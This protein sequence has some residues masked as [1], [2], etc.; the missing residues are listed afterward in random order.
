MKFKANGW[1][2]GEKYFKKSHKAFYCSIGHPDRRREERRLGTDASMADDLRTEI[3]SSIIRDGAPSLDMGV[4]ELCKLFLEHSKANQSTKTYLGYRG[5]L[6][7]FTNTLSPNL[8][9]RDLL[10]A[11]VE[12][13]L[14]RIYPAKTT[15][16]NTRRGAVVAVKRV[17][18]WAVKQMGWIDRSPL[19]GYPTP[20]AVP[21]K[22]LLT[23][24]QWAV[25][26][27]HY[28]PED[29]FHDFLRVMVCTGCRP[30]EVRIIAARHIDWKRQ[31]ARLAE[32][33]VPG[34]KLARVVRLPSDVVA[35]LQKWAAKYPDGP[36]L[37][38]ADGNPWTANAVT[39]RF[40]RLQKK[41][42]GFRPFAYLARHSF[43]T[44]LSQTGDASVGEVA[45]I[46]G[47]TDATMVLKVYGNH[48]DNRQDH[49]LN[50]VE[51]VDPLGEK[52]KRGEEVSDAQADDGDGE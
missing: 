50:C 11:H 9:V 51:R 17:F 23:P 31:V 29:P 26:L 4:R 6:L 34:K 1:V 21:R 16:P 30:Q 35:I 47:H 14:T 42:T 18:N 28:R 25:V 7:S 43:I 5:L 40:R 36:M 22:T 20:R 46:S 39:S 2:V 33:E 32:G 48:F 8:R 10:K 52:A 3:I 12:N 49:L 45:E 15:N 44:L 27:S 24:E 13:W 19:E 38:N 41:V 37:R